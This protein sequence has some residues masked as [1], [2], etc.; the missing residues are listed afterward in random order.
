MPTL[1][2]LMGLAKLGG[3]VEG[4]ERVKRKAV[5][6]WEGAHKGQGRGGEEVAAGRRF[7][8]AGAV[9]E[10]AVRSDALETIGQYVQQKA[11]DEFLRV[12]RHGLLLAI[13]AI[14]LVA[15]CELVLVDV[16]QAIVGEGYA[17]GVAPDV[18]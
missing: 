1:C 16:Q 6:R 10:K 13:M 3:L 8:C 18:I 2:G 9:A 7:V 11:T 12:Q 17:V 14:I 15:E 5:G 4:C